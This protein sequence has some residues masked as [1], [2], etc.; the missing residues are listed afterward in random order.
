VRVFGTVREGGPFENVLVRV[1]VTAGD[2]IQRIEF[3]DIGDA[4]QALARFDELCAS[5]P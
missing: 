1:I 3:F 2:H 4:D 5:L